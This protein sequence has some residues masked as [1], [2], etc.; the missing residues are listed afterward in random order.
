M[1]RGTEKILTE[2]SKSFSFSMGHYVALI[3]MI[4]ARDRH[5]GALNAS[6]IGVF[7]A[8]MN[9]TASPRETVRLFH[10]GNPCDCLKEGIQ[11]ERQTAGTVKN[12]MIFGRSV[13]VSAK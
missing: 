2:I 3:K 9:D 8:Q 13:S 11:R 12:R 4:E 5:D 6:T 1:G 10:R 7:H